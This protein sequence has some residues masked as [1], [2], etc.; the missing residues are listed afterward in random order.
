MSRQLLTSDIA[1]VTMT[2]INIGATALF[3]APTLA[4]RYAK[5]VG[6]IVMPGVAQFVIVGARPFVV[7][8]FFIHHCD[9]AALTHTFKPCNMY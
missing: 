7:L 8:V 4:G 5:R 3:P 2:R 9:V 6:L 1:Y